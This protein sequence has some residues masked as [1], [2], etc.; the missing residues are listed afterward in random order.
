MQDIKNGTIVMDINT[1]ELFAVLSRGANVIKLGRYIPEL[2]AVDYSSTTIVG[3]RTFKDDFMSY[4][5]YLQSCDNMYTRIMTACDSESP[6]VD[7]PEYAYESADAFVHWIRN[8]NTEASTPQTLTQIAQNHWDWVEKMGWHNKTVLESLALIASE[9]GESVNECRG[10][11]PTPLLGGELADII[12]RVI[13]LSVSQNI[14]IEREVLAKMA[15][16]VQ[17]GTR[18][19]AK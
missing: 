11:Q 7:I 14:D 15:L 5:A 6:C 13:D 1:R 3:T 12:L 19:R 17:R 8:R 4:D 16:N 18:G 9:V 2:D 10:E